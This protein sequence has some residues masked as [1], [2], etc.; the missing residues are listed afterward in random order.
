MT[1]QF[2]F[3]SLFFFFG[4][5][6][7]SSLNQAL[8]RTKRL[9]LQRQLRLL[10]KLFFYLP[11]AKKITSPI[12]EGLPF[13]TVISLNFSRFLS[14]FFF[15]LWLGTE[16]E[17]L[18][19]LWI[20]IPLLVFAILLF[21]LLG[22]YAPKAWADRNPLRAL[23]FSCPTSSPYLILSSPFC[24][25]GFKLLKKYGSKA[26]LQLFQ[27]PMGELKQEILDIIQ[28]G[29]FNAQLTA[30][31]KKLIESVVRFQTK[32]ARE[33]MVPR[34][35]VFSINVET[36]IQDAAKALQ[37]EGYSRVPVYRE[38][39]DD[40]AGILMY[41]D[42]LGY[43]LAYRDSGNDKELLKGSVEELLK[44]VFYTPETKKISN[45]LQEFKKKQSHLAVVVDEYGGTAGIVTIEDLLEEIVGEIEDEYDEEESYI[46][47][48]SKG[49]WIVDGRLTLLDAEEQLG[50][51]LPQEGEY[52]TIGGYLFHC[53]GAIPKKGFKIQL[54][55]AELEV[56]KS[57]DRRV[58]KV[59]ITTKSTH[60]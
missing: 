27:E 36:S 9:E 1:A 28:G 31:D 23:W 29:E 52:D 21:Y 16:G 53:A 60:G 30:H 59:K 54:D 17:Y 25:A 2:L 45:L 42:L 51:S 33:V 38:T 41:R 49:V 40:I 19:S 43:F 56:V 5:F 35:D 32:I 6:S 18:A 46:S 12:E 55:E 7:L 57:N 48:L 8:K 50:L 39:I 44:P 13:S 47:T 34:I 15:S 20:S 11:L 3:L 24:F 26:T 37:K 10:G 4:V 58:E 14:I 22:D